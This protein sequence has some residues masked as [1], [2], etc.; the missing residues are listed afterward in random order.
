MAAFPKMIG[1]DRFF[2]YDN[3]SSDGGRDL[4]SRS[5]FAHTVTL[6]D[7]PEATGGELSAY[8]HFRV[9]T[10]PREFTWAAFITDN[11]R[12]NL[13]RSRA[14]RFLN[15]PEARRVYRPFAAILLQW[16]G[17]RPMRPSTAGPRGW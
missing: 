3:G 2:L 11:E 1:V 10:T 15:D 7:W 16:S 8:N 5:S 17:V 14:A 4:I 9:H 13:C 12:I 6:T